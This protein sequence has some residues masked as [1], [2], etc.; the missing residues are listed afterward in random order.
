LANWEFETDVF[1]A[2]GHP[3]DY[4]Y[5]DGLTAFIYRAVRI[6]GDDSEVPRR[7]I[8]VGITRDDA[9]INLQKHIRE[10]DRAAVMP[11]LTQ[12]RQRA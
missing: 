10:V 5:G 4:Y 8:G 6:G 12:N 7:V 11:S 3:K 1:T 2:G 9:I